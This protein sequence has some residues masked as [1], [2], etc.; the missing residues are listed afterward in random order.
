MA[1]LPFESF[2]CPIKSIRTMYLPSASR[3]G[4]DSILLKFIFLDANSPSD[5]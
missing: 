4:L 3:V 5:S 2:L 1:D